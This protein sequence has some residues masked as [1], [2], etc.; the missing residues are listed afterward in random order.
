MLPLARRAAGIIAA[1][2]ASLAGGAAAARSAARKAP[3]RA[4]AAP[5]ATKVRRVVGW[6]RMATPPGRARGRKAP[7]SITSSSRDRGGDG[8]C[9]RRAPVDEGAV[10]ALGA[11]HADHVEAHPERGLHGADD[12]LAQLVL[13]RRDGADAAQIGAAYEHRRRFRHVG[14]DRKLVEPREG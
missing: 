4:K 6:I 14:L 3:A 11:V 9:L 13:E 8:C 2:F 12:R 7:S 5:S 1:S 10:A